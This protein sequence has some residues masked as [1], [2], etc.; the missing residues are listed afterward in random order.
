MAIDLLTPEDAAERLH[1]RPQTLRAYLRKGKIRGFHVAGKW[2]L[3]HEAFD[4]FV[5]ELELSQRKSGVA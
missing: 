1:M 5:R 3:T 2:M 4:E